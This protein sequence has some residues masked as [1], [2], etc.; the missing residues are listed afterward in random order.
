MIHLRSTYKL[1]ICVFWRRLQRGR[2][3]SNNLI[4]EIYFQVHKTIWVCLNNVLV[5]NVRQVFDE[6]EVELN[7]VGWN[8]MIVGFGRQKECNN[9]GEFSNLVD[10]GMVPGLLRNGKSIDDS[11]C[12]V[13]G[14]SFGSSVVRVLG[15][16]GMVPDE[17]NSFSY[18]D[19][20]LQCLRGMQRLLMI[21]C[22]LGSS[23]VRVLGALRAISDMGWNAMIVGFGRQE[24]CNNVME[25]FNLVEGRGNG[26]R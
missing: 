18:F 3:F 14:S 16:M 24:E 25:L 2:S 7:V 6:Q 19:G 22:G 9:V 4:T 11:S 23:V 21:Y 12:F 13:E 10:Q 15:M 26:G 5:G 17:Y 8:A 1:D 20:V